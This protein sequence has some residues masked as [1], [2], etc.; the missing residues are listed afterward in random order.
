MLHHFMNFQHLCTVYTQYYGVPFPCNNTKLLPFCPSF[1]IF[2]KTCFI[3]VHTVSE[4]RTNPSYFNEFTI[5]WIHMFSI[6]NWHNILG[7]HY[8]TK[9]T[10]CSCFVHNLLCLLWEK[11]VLVHLLLES[12]STSYT[13]VSF[14]IFCT[15]LAQYCNCPILFI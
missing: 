10:I 1:V 15:A 4:W 2:S 13:S 14:Q 7:C 11:Y 5:Q 6:V 12:I 9:S 8:S 3:L